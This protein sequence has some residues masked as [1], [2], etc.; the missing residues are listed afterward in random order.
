MLAVNLDWNPRIALMGF[1]SYK[2][3]WIHFKRTSD[4]YILYVILSGA[5]Y[6]EENGHRYNLQQ[7]DVFML[8]PGLEHEGFE[9]HACDYYFI[10]F[11]HPDISSIVVDDLQA[12]AHAFFREDHEPDAKNRCCFSKYFSLP[13]KSAMSQILGILNEMQQLYRRKTYNQGMTAL[14]L[15]ELF[16]RLSREN[17]LAVL[18]KSRK[19]P[20]K[21]IV[22]AYE[23]LDYIHQHYPSKLTSERIEREFKCN[24]DYLNRTFNKLAGYSIAYYINKVRID[25]SRELLETTRLSIGEIARLVGF[26]DVYHFSK[27]FKK[28]AGVAPT[29]YGKEP[30]DADLK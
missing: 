23:L 22:I 21:S 1:V 5:L 8:E 12:I 19:R 25:H 2:N 28:F 18:Q 29:A 13:N 9:M 16:I 17:M 30:Q 6:I 10:H 3:P 26:A 11:K 24:F 20:T 14:K 15:S 7:G 27:V 4:E